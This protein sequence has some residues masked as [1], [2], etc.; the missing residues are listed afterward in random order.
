MSRFLFI[1]KQQLQ[2]SPTELSQHAVHLWN[3]RE[4]EMGELKGKT[5]QNRNNSS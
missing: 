2:K 4:L 3:K 5:K 1:E